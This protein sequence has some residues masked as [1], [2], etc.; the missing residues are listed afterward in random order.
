MTNERKEGKGKGK[1]EHRGDE[2]TTVDERIWRMLTCLG[3]LNSPDCLDP[4][5]L[6]RWRDGRRGSEARKEVLDCVEEV[7]REHWRVAVSFTAELL[8]GADQW[9][10]PL[11]DVAGGTTRPGELTTPDEGQD[12]ALCAIFDRIKKEVSVLDDMESTVHGP[13]CWLSGPCWRCRLE[14]TQRTQRVSK[15]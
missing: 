8:A 1:K 14:Q 13:V 7:G 15:E 3:C 12:Q 9:N 6:L 2:P 4:G 10:E 5:E 11:S